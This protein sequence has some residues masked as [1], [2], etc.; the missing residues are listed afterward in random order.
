MLSNLNDL[1]LSD[2]RLGDIPDVVLMAILLLALYGA[3]Q[4]WNKWKAYRNGW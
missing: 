4:L 2:L 3:G 1:Y